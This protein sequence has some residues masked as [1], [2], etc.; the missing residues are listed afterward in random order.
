MGRLTRSRA[1]AQVSSSPPVA[2][3]VSVVIPIPEKKVFRPISIR[4]PEDY[5]KLTTFEAIPT[6]VLQIIQLFLNKTDY[7][8]LLNTNATIFQHSKFETVYYNFIG[9]EK[10]KRALGFTNATEQKDYFTELYAS[11]KDKSKQISLN[12][13]NPNE[14]LVKEYSH[15]MTGIHHLTFTDRQ[16]GGFWRNDIDMNAFCNIYHLCLKNL[17]GIDCLRGLHDIKILEVHESM[18]LL[19]IE[20]IPGL[21]RLVLYRLLE[22]C[23]LPEEYNSIPELVIT[24]CYK[25]N[26]KK[27]QKNHNK[28]KIGSIN[29]DLTDLT[30]FSK[31]TCLSSADIMNYNFHS[32]AH[33][34]YLDI[35]YSYMT[36][37]IFNP[38]PLMKLRY[39][40]LDFA[41]MMIENGMFP[42]LLEI[43][44]FSNCEFDNVS[45]VSHVKVLTFNKCHGI[46]F[47]NV[48][49]LSKV[50]K[51]TFDNIRELED[52]SGLDSLYELH[53]LNCENLK[54]ISKLGRVHRLLV[55]C[56][57][58]PVTSLEGLG[59][60]NSK[61]YLGGLSKVTDFTPLRSVYK[62]SLGNCDSIVHGRDL[63]SVQ[64]LILYRCSAFDDTSALGNLKS[65]YLK[66]CWKISKL[67]GLENVPTIRIEGCNE[68]EDIS[69]L[70]KQQSLIILKC[71]KLSRKRGKYEDMF[72]H[73]PFFRFNLEEPPR[74]FPL[75]NFPSMFSDKIIIDE[76]N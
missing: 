62:V 9:Y 36:A 70:G 17:Q 42:P 24:A 49:S 21:K 66:E 51:L 71:K 31:V 34:V 74:S 26:L 72:A 41:K 20:F 33:L 12:V 75:S 22:I 19:T 35:L 69:C 60:G 25:L 32:F 67:D 64:H 63:A 15:F 46:G 57:G 5:Y 59:Q 2:V 61:I 58:R 44:E 48:S 4:A 76:V 54:D 37:R 73:I 52:V 1:K 7:R 45:I 6:S 30:I 23:E 55:S 65:F 16:S 53:L 10:W 40:K 39:L 68:L 27:G 3:D 43:A 29:R 28:V 11:V 14:K 50:H 18:T 8:Q 56:W 47:N 13:K 38:S